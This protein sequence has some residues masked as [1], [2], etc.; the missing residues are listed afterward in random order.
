METR[1]EKNYEFIKAVSNIFELNYDDIKIFNDLNTLMDST[2]IAVIF[3]FYVRISLL[4]L[5]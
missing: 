1:F 4:L 3:K 2:A 5:Q